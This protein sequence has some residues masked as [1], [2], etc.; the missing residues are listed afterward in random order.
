MGARHGKAS[1][2][3]QENAANT[4]G[5]LTLIDGSKEANIH[6]IGAGYTKHDFSLGQDSGKGTFISFV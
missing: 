6:F 3:Y 2:S 4:G 5:V 1:F